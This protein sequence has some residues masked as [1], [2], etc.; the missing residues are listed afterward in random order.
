LHALHQMNLETD[1]T[2]HIEMDERQLADLKAAA[3]RSLLELAATGPRGLQALEEAV[4][5]VR[6]VSYGLSLLRAG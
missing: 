3:L 2:S 6:D 5:E 1:Y 4:Q